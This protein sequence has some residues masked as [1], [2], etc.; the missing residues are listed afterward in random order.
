MHYSAMAFSGNG[1]ETMHALKNPRGRLMGQRNE[2]TRE[3][4][5]RINLMYDCPANI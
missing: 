3:D 4:L 1:L 2:V 5:L